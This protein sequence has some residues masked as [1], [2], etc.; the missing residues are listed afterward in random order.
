[1]PPSPQLKFNNVTEHITH[2]VPSRSGFS[3]VGWNTAPDGTGT[4]WAANQAYTANAPLTLYASWEGIPIPVIV[5]DNLG[6]GFAVIE[7]EAAAFSPFAFGAF[8]LSTTSQ[9]QP[10]ETVIISALPAHGYEFSHWQNAYGEIISRNP[11]FEVTILPQMTEAQLT[12]TAIFTP[13]PLLLPPLPLPLPDEYEYDEEPAK[14][15]DAPPAKEPEEPEEHNDPND[16]ID[17]E[18]ENDPDDD[19][20][21]KPKEESYDPN[22]NDEQD[23]EQ[24]TDI[25][26]TGYY[27][28]KYKEA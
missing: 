12:I 7:N 15:E 26:T 23:P 10:G 4:A 24:D 28:Q 1:M 19:P 2:I 20:L 5:G 13:L 16:P 6:G 22:P 25:P 11:R 8:D 3:F 18:V 27:K 21:D 9:F 14:E 17:P